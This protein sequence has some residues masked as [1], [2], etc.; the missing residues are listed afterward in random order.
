MAVEKAQFNKWLNKTHPGVRLTHMQRNWI[1][2]KLRGEDP[3]MSDW[4][5]ASG[6]TFILELWNEY[7]EEVLMQ[8]DQE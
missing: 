3:V 2:A 5:R 4:P 7:V 6:K 8:G 1:D